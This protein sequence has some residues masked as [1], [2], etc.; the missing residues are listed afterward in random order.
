[1]LN[2][3]RLI[4]GL[5]SATL[6]FSS[7]SLPAFAEKSSQYETLFENEITLANNDTTIYTDGTYEGTGTGKKG[8]ITLSVTITDGKISSI[9]EVSQSETES[10]WKKAK[11]LFETI[12][13]EQSTDVDSISSATL[14]S[15]GIKEAVNNALA[16]AVSSGIFAS[17]NG[18]E[19][20]P[21]TIKTK[22][23]LLAFAKSVD[24]GETY[25]DK[26]ISLNE[27]IDLSDVENFNSIGDESGT[28]NIFNGCFN[29]NNNTISNMKITRNYSAQTNV[30]LFSTL[31]QKASVKNLKVTNADIN[32]TATSIIRAGIISGNTTASGS[33]IDSCYT[34]GSVK[35]SSDNAVLVYGGGI[36]GQVQASVFVTNSISSAD[37]SSESKGGNNSAYAGGITG[38]SGNNSVIAN[39]ASLGNI[40]A[41]SPKSTNFGGMAGGIT[42]MAANKQYNC[43]ALGNTTIG[44]AGTAHQWVGVLNGE[45]TTA[46]M[47]KDTNGVFQYPEEGAL[48]AYN[49][50]ASDTVQTVEKWI[51]TV[52]TE[53]AVTISP[54]QATGTTTSTTQYDKQFTAESLT[55]AE[56]KTAEF[57]EKL[58]SNLYSVYKLLKAYSLN[59]EIQLKEWTFEN[60]NVV[61]GD[62]TWVNDVIDESIFESGKG[63][64]EDPY[65]IKTEDQLRAFAL[66]LTNK[67]D[68]TN[69][70]I[71]LGN[72]IDI[73]SKEWTPIGK[74]DYAFNGNFDGKGYSV[75]GLNIG[76]SDAPLAIEKG[77]IF[78]G[79]F[80]VLGENA[81]V[82]NLKLTG[83]AIYTSYEATTY[84]GG[85]AGYMNG[86]SSSYKGTLIDSCEIDGKI[87][88]TATAGNNLVGG[89][90]GQQYKGSII[91]T[92][93]NMDLSCT[94]TS[95]YLAEVGGIVGLNNRGLV[96]NCY[97]LGNAYGSGLRSAEG[98]GVVSTLIGCNAGNLVNC[99]TNGSNK[100]DDYSQ[101]VGAVSG[102]V[103][104]IGKSY[105][106]YYNE[107]AEMTLGTQKVSPVE[108]IGTKIASGVNDEGDAY[109]GGVVYGMTG[110]STESYPTIVNGLND[111]FAK[112]PIDI[113]IYG[114][115]NTALKNW[116]YN[117][118]TSSVT[119]GDSYNTVNYVQPDAEIVV[120]E[121]PTLKDGVWY[122]RNDDKTSIV[123]IEVKDKE[124]SNIE[125]ISGENNG[126][127]Y[128]KAL[129]KAKEKSSFGD[130]SG[131]GKGDI[132][133][134]DSGSGTAEDPFLISTEKQLRYL[135][136]SVNADED[137]AG[138]NFALKNDIDLK[139]G[140][141]APIG[142]AIYAEI[143]G[144]S[145]LYCAYPFRGNFD[146][147]NKTVG[148]L[149]I[150]T[151]ENPSDV[152]TAAFFGITSGDYTSNGT[153]EDFKDT[154]SITVKNLNLKDIDINV[155]NRY[156]NYTG[157]LIGS[158]QY[159]IFVDNCSVTGK[160]NSY[161]KE[162]ISRAGGLISYAIR[163]AVTNSYTDVEIN[164][165]TD[166]S[167]SYG[168]GL[169]ASTN[170]VTVVNCYSIGNVTG[171]AGNNNKVQIGG[172]TGQHGGIQINC[173]SSGNVI[174]LKSTS[175]VGGINGRITGIGIDYNCYYNSEAIQQNGATINETNVASGTVVSGS[176]EESTDKT[177]TELESTDFAELLNEN[178]ENVSLIIDNEITT[179]LN[180]VQES[181][182]LS[183]PIYYK[184][185][186]LLSWELK[187][188]IVGFK[189]SSDNPETLDLYKFGSTKTS[190]TKGSYLLP[191]KM[192]N[193]TDIT[194]PSIASSCIKN[195]KLTV[196]DSG[197][198]KV[199]IDLQP[200]T[201][202]GSA[203]F[204]KTWKVYQENST[205][206]KLVN[207]EYTTDSEG[208]VNQISFDIFD[209]SLD[210][211]YVNLTLDSA[212]DAYIN[213][214]FAN[215]EKIS[216]IL[217]DIN[218]DE[219]VD[220]NDASLLLQYI[221]DQNSV[222]I[223]QYGLMNAKVLG[224]ENITAND[225]SAIV[226]KALDTNFEFPVSK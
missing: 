33:K 124:I 52:T 148:G 126:D 104:G 202:E 24:D 222:A 218:C 132:S 215:V 142:F 105:V 119:F 25:E 216:E 220:I 22:E 43:Y 203:S 114:L 35:V 164:V 81:I 99:Y 83:I 170:R 181:L 61:L 12:I 224:N 198:A 44:N 88:H 63:S 59:D 146:G 49:Y 204:T 96:A 53:S 193:T 60:E 82:K 121:D 165:D 189:E 139:D 36:T 194:S 19:S 103:T 169:F 129:E 166:S 56:I 134:F 71:S 76:K 154:R 226:Q 58:N 115:E 211:I 20:S 112:F 200:I 138:Y 9:T 167:T 97:T 106:C 39:C 27:N 14:S 186:S 213:F 217:G 192:M 4:A 201:N 110:Y 225:V 75:S 48:R 156:L 45:I 84:I 214:D 79:F 109:T 179:H 32:T 197:K 93:T 144:A 92:K 46:S 174:S 210:G 185:N 127:A 176:L 37:V 108:S 118:E 168:G 62:E 158:G 120:K 205:S 206:G 100:T 70:F 66:S 101:Y 77:N 151:E 68:Y 147:K 40:Y 17:G 23:Q 196:L 207:A 11:A 31:G 116:V 5:I 87:V 1:M 90:V 34:D 195:A 150:G 91:N 125:V 94:V 212:I 47:K 223:N 178:K 183:H 57:A 85:V 30:G 133:V 41:S 140:D 155:A 21:Y 208:N 199:T 73:S 18:S 145:K 3:K 7:F 136:T 80:G 175:D 123:K 153:L 122:G 54:V 177:K 74:S 26:F 10:F 162:G 143:N 98:M 163:G 42:G 113:T 29:G 111:V 137:W 51:D 13:T 69:T 28:V 2:K 6:T 8:D 15:D 209:N 182:N 180:N 55:T 67:I 152:N 171:N 187:D 191:L 157:G 135:A 141:W 102:W 173:Y 95:G 64:E 16:K 131:Y 219:K 38:M 190:L 65:I 50:Y 128:N 159:G 117:S 130:Y 89:V 149:K 72:N 161:S 160:I 221:L 188:K 107:N 184:G 78:V 172:L 86:S